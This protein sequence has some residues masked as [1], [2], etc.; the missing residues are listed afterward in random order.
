MLIF[1]WAFNTNLNAH[2]LGRECRLARLSMRCRWQFRQ[3]NVDGEFLVGSRHTEPHQQTG[4]R[5]R[6]RTTTVHHLQQARRALLHPR[7]WQQVQGQVTAVSV[8]F[9]QLLLSIL[10]SSDLI[11]TCS[12][13]AGCC[14]VALQWPLQRCLAMSF[15]LNVYPSQ[16]NFL[17]LSWSSLLLAVYYSPS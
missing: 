17:L 16:F 9:Q 6:E 5:A 12:L 11:S 1:N 10:L 8:F 7:Q 2:R 14:S 3:D 15:L 13:V 4:G